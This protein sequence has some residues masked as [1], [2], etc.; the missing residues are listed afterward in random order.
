MRER[1]SPEAPLGTAVTVAPPAAPD[2]AGRASPT[3]SA[4]GPSSCATAAPI[5]R[6]RRGFHRGQIAP[7]HPRTAVGQLAD[8]G[9]ILVVVDGRSGCE[10]RADAR[11][12]SRGD[13]PTRAP[14]PRWAS[15]AAARRRSP[16]TGAS[17]TLPRTGVRAPSRR[18]GSSSS[19][20]ASTR[21]SR[22]TAVLSPNGD[23]VADVQRLAAKLV[24]RSARAGCG[25]CARTGRWRWSSRRTCVEPGLAAHVVA[26]PVDAGRPLA[27]GWPRPTDAGDRLQ[28]P[29]GAGVSASTRRSATCA[30]RAGACASAAA[31]AALGISVLAHAAGSASTSPSRRADGRPRRRLF[32]GRARPGTQVW[33]WDGRNAAGRVVPRGRATSFGVA[34]TNELGA[35]A[36]RAAVARSLRAVRLRARVLRGARDHR[37]RHR[38]DRRLRPLRRLHPHVHRRRPAGGERARHGLRR[39]GRGRRV[40]GLRGHA[41]RAARSSPRRWAYFAMAMAGTIGYTLGSIARLGDRRSTAGG[42]YLESHG[43]W[44]HVTPEKLD[45]A[46][47]WFERYGDATVFFDA[48]APGRPLV[49]LHPGRDRARCRSAATR[50]SRSSGRSRGASASRPSASRSAASG[51]EFH[52]SFRYADYAIVALVVAGI[53]AVVLPR[54][55]AAG[56]RKRAVEERSVEG[57]GAVDWPAVSLPRLRASAMTIPHVDVKAQYAPLLRRAEGAARRRARLGPLHPRPRGARLRGGGGRLSRR[58]AEAV[59]VANGTDALVLV[60]DALGVGP[61]DEVVCPA[62]TFYATAEA[63]ARVGATPVF[64]D[65]DPATLNLDPADVADRVGERTKAILAVHLFGRPAPLEELPPGVP[66]IEDA[67]QAFGATLGAQRAGALGAAG[68]FSFFPTKNLFGLGDGGLVDDERRR[69]SPSASGSCAS[70]APA[71]RSASRRSGKLPARRDPGGRA[72]PLPRPPRRLERRPA[73]GG[74]ALRGA[75]AWASSASSLRTSPATSTTCTSCAPPSATAS[76]RRCARQVSAAP[77]TTRRRSTCSRSTPVSA[78]RPGSLPETERAAPR[79]DRPAAL[80]GYR[81]PAQQEASSATIS[82]AVADRSGA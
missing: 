57:T 62:F 75:R 34:A 27:A 81:R 54:R 18:T 2:S 12:R 43:R 3:R 21:P 48:H 44:L 26:E 36:L 71:T 55:T 17:S 63:I 14:S 73:G 72:A 42:P 9:V 7:R 5:V 56:A 16:S 11:G 22:A 15:T 35:V 39:R 30:S 6:A 10:P 1:C 68:T 66:V 19:T 50:C 4:A 41:L 8:G 45:Q 52:E 58:A 80:G 53:G 37:G 38:R 33:R 74:R 46:E 76:P 29:H 60:L 78:T 25:S 77:R 67:A 82:T 59:G 24:R 65:I 20:T 47:A 69:R 70:T 79:D 32:R 13:G 23:G 64:C 51:S 28:E 31:A 40:P 61:G 49:R